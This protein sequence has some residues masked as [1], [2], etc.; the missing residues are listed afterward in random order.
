MKYASWQGLIDYIKMTDYQ[1]GK[2]I[3]A[4]YTAAEVLE[5]YEDWLRIHNF[6][7]E[8]DNDNLN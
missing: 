2:R 7:E 5:E 6:K 8:K 3:R 4:L 1:V